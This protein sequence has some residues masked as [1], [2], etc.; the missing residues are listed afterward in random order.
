MENLSPAGIP[1]E[2]LLGTGTL[3]ADTRALSITVLLGAVAVLSLLFSLSLS[4][5]LPPSISLC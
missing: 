3:S 4:L 5:S 2:V 1:I